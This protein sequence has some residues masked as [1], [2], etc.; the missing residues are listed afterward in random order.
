M[1]VDETAC[2]LRRQRRGWIEP[3]NQQQCRRSRSIA[4]LRLRLQHAAVLDAWLVN[5]VTM[6]RSEKV[7]HG[8]LASIAIT[9]LL[10]SACG[11]KAAALAAKWNY[12]FDAQVGTHGTQRNVLRFLNERHLPTYVD[13]ERH[14]VTASRPDVDQ[15]GVVTYGVYLTFYF[16][17]RGTLLKHE[18][19]AIGTGP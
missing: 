15:H 1:F 11:D 19:A 18:I 7:L 9:V 10:L 12:E 8:N 4:A 5:A 14:L 3:D 16:D 17:D 13:N 6:K 2:S